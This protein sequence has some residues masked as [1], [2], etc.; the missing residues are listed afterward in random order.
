MQ[1]PD[2]LGVVRGCLVNQIP[3][4]SAHKTSEAGA[5]KEHSDVGLSQ[6]LLLKLFHFSHAIEKLNIHWASERVRM[7]IS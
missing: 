2:L 7:T 5:L 6:S 1:G 3:Q 4:V